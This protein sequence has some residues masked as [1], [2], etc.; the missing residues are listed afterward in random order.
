MKNTKKCLIF[1]IGSFLLHS[2]DDNHDMNNILWSPDNHWE[3]IIQID[4]N[5]DTAEFLNNATNRKHTMISVDEELK[6]KAKIT[7][8][9]LDKIIDVDFLD[10][11]DQDKFNTLIK[12]INHKLDLDLNFD[13]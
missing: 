7:E 8:L 5:N 11:L 10:L 4:Y 13:L 9:Y 12:R 2:Y 3:Y 6:C 1:L